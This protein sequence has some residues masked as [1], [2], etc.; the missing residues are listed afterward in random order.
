[1]KYSN[2]KKDVPSSLPILDL[3]LRNITHVL[4]VSH[5]VGYLNPE[6]SYW[7]Q[8]CLKYFQN[9]FE[10]GECFFQ[11]NEIYTTNGVCQPNLINSSLDPV[12]RISQLLKAAIAENMSETKKELETLAE[13]HDGAK[14]LIER[15]TDSYRNLKVHKII[16]TTKSTFIIILQIKYC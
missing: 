1:M 9:L 15:M 16:I 13:C 6:E 14:L 12:S 5:K 11:E 8:K 3:N 4:A 2:I 7:Y 10:Y